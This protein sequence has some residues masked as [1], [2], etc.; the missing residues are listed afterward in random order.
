VTNHHDTILLSCDGKKSLKKVT[1]K[2]RMMKLIGILKEMPVL[3]KR[4]NDESKKN[5]EDTKK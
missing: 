4:S 5:N 3:I 2:I 1:Q